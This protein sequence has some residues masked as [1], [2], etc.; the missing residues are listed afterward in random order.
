MKDAVVKFE[1][2]SFRYQTL[3]TKS[4]EDINLEIYKGEKVLI[5]G[6]SGSG[7]S[8]LLHCLNGIIPF[9][10]AGDIEGKL[11]LTDI[12]PYKT[13]IFEVSKKV[14]TILQDQD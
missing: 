11:T 1:N 6:R 9:A 5:T 8:T 2:F 4:L 3:Q 13:S 7:K 10:N 14:G 12:E